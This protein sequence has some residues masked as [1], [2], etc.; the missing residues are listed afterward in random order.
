MHDS[1]GVKIQPIAAEGGMLKVNR[2]L[3][4][5]QVHFQLVSLKKKNIAILTI[6]ET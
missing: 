1:I 3:G 5:K 2:F 6:A 4:C